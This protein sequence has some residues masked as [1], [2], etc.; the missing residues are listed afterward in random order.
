[1][2]QRLYEFVAEPDAAFPGRPFT[3]DGHLVGALGEV[4]ASH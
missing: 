2:V 3:L 4:L 1:V